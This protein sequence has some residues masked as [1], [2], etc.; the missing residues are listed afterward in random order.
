M[1]LEFGNLE[2]IAAIKKAEKEAEDLTKL[3]K[4]SVAVSWE[5]YST[6]EVEAVSEE[7]AK[8][9]ALGEVDISDL[10]NIDFDIRRVD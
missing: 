1:K 7:D 8:E 9:K 10:S 3:K 5:G 4:Y 6:F 2:Q